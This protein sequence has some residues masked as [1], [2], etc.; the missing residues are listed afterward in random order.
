MCRS[1]IYFHLSLYLLLQLKN[2]VQWEWLYCRYKR[3]RLLVP[4]KSFSR[5]VL[6]KHRARIS[7][8]FKSSGIDSASL[9]WRAVKITLFLV[10]AR[11]A[12]LHRL[13][14]SIPWNR[15]LGIDS[16][17]PSSN[18]YKYGLCCPKKV[19]VLDCKHS[20]IYLQ[21]WTNICRIPVVGKSRPSI[22]RPR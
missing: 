17:T 1:N 8:C 20:F 4:M 14:E 16:W 18:V 6:H 12:T 22:K 15:F 11:Q 19:F 3:N 5:W 2:V 10:P 7:K 9:V 13:A 21:T